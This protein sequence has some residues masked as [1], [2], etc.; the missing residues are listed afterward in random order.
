MSVHNRGHL[1]KDHFCQH[2]WKQFISKSGLFNIVG[3]PWVSP[4]ANPPKYLRVICKSCRLLIEISQSQHYGM[5]KRRFWLVDCHR[6][7]VVRPM[8]WIVHTYFFVESGL[9]FRNSYERVSD[10]L[11]K[12]LVFINSSQNNF[13]NIN[14]CL[15][16][17]DNY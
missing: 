5:I 13:I 4:V 7:L 15:N 1:K 9:W 11:C 3:K 8:K 17:L 14:L 16:E 10:I 6:N 12:S 2:C